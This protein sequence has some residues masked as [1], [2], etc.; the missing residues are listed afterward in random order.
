MTG[1][2]CKDVHDVQDF[3][4]VDKQ[5]DPKGKDLPLH[6]FQEIAEHHMEIQAMQA[7][8]LRH[9]SQLKEQVELQDLEAQGLAEAEPAAAWPVVEL[10]S[11]ED[12]LTVRQALEISDP[13][14]GAVD[15][16]D[17]QLCAYIQ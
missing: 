15:P 14:P 12:N 5:I 4:Q 3:V 9:S 7:H 2:M 1:D 17:A 6:W 11:S 16:E 10:L 13:R 8:K